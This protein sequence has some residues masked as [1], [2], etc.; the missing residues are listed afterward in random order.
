VGCITWRPWD[1]SFSEDDQVSA[2]GRTAG[3]IFVGVIVGMKLRKILTFLGLLLVVP[4]LLLLN[5]CGGSSSANVITVSVTSSVGTVLILGQSTTLTATVTGSTNTN[6]TW[7]TGVCTYTIIPAGSTKANPA[8]ACPTDGTFGTLTNVQTTGTATYT[9]PTKLPDQTKFPSLALI[10]TATSQANTAKTGTVTIALTSGIA[11][12]LTPVTA[13]VPTKESKPFFVALDNDLQ[14]KGV[15][16]LITQST[17]TSTTTISQLPTCSPGCGTIT[18]L[19]SDPI[20]QA[21][22]TAPATV[23][24]STTVTTTPANVTLVATAVSDN[25]CSTCVAAGTITIIQGGPITFNGISPTIA[26]QGAFYWDIYLDAPNMS[27]STQIALDGV[28]LDPNATSYAQVKI[29]FPIPTSATPTPSSTGARLRLFAPPLAKA[30]P[31]LITLS[32]SGQTVTTPNPASAYTYNVLPVRATSTATVPDDVVQGK[33]A[34]T[35][36]VTVDGG[37]F[38]PGG[39]LA[40]VTFQGS[41]V[42]TDPNT[43]TARRLNASLLTSQI[44]S[45]GP[46]L[47][48]LSVARTIPPVPSPNNPAVTNIAIFPDYSANPPELLTK[49]TP[50][51]PPTPAGINP[52]AMDID[53]AL[54]VVVVAETG[55]NQIQFY[56]VIPPAGLAP[57][58]LTPIDQSGNP[59]ATSCPV[60]ST[61][62]APLN[63]PTGLSVNSSDHTVAVVN[64]GT[65]TKDMN[66]NVV[67]VGQS[68]TVLPIPGAPGTPIAPFSLDI[69]GAYHGAFLG[70]S[71]PIPMPYSIGV[72]PDSKLVLV[73]YSST[74]N[75]SSANLGFVVNLNTGSN[76]PFGCLDPTVTT[77]PC[78]HSQVTLNTGAYPHIAVAAH[79]HL[80][81]VTPGGSGVVQGV[82]LTKKSTSTQIASVSL[83]AGQVTVTTTT[84]H[85]LIP[86]N[87]G[88]VLITGVPNTNN[89][90]V[91]F[92]GVFSVAVTSNMTFTYAL[93]STESDSETGGTNSFVF[94]S[95]PNLLFQISPSLQGIAINP[96]TQTA[97][98]ANAD[99]TG[100]NGA[101]IDMLSAL[102]QSTSSISFSANC[103]AYTVPCNTAPELLATTDV[104][105]QPYTNALISYN[106]QQALVSVSDPNSHQRQ[107]I[108]TGFGPSAVAFP[109]TNGTTGTLTLWGGVVVDSAT[110]HA[111][112]LESGSGPQQAGHI[113][114]VNLG[115]AS[116]NNIKPTQI[117]E[118]I[119][120][121]AT[122]GILGGIPNAL[123][124]Q[125]TLT[126]TTDLSNVKIL[127]SGFGAPAI[128]R[129]DGVSITGSSFPTGSVTVVSSREIDVT[130][131]AAFLSAPHRYSVDLTSTFNGNSVQSNTT[132]FIVVQAIDMSKVCAGG[133]VQPSA[134]AIAD[135]LAN[136]AFSPIA[137]VTNSGCNSI[138]VIDV[139]PTITMGGVTM[140]NPTFGAVRNTV[141]VGTTPQGVAISQRRGL[142]VVANNGD[143]TAS[144]ID[145]TLTTPAAKVPAVAT[146]T[147]PIGVAVD[148][149]LGVAI[150]TNNTS[151]TISELNLGLLF[152]PAGTTP[153]TTLTS[154]SIGGVQQPIAV[155]IDPD[156]GTNNQGIAVVTALQLVS[157]SAPSGAL[158]VVD[159]GLATPSL[160]TTI[161]SG[162]VTA[163]PTGIVFD[164]TVATGTQNPGEFYANSSG[165]N[166]ISVFN[167]DTGGG[168]SV[169]VGINPTSLALNPQTGAIL[170]A[171]SASNTISIVDSLSLPFKTHQTLGIPGSPTF[172]VAIDPFTNLG[173]IVDQANSRVFLFPMPN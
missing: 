99:A 1:E 164:P 152:P 157:G 88:T 47:Y 150:V 78:I 98:L 34:Q 162:S 102:D 146:G 22:Y 107:A 135:Q 33:L 25:N 6:V 166:V 172:G 31:H 170:T 13:T 136:G 138:S 110:N 103:T 48:P 91:D 90:N 16:W 55:S 119:V 134:V 56:K 53:T 72:D 15:T 121:G 49:A 51:V 74:S 161:S 109:V 116:N 108:V 76:P 5:G 94:Y 8:V 11:V 82:D 3:R 37:Y 24:T 29:L 10:F 167:P 80:A 79:S 123:V 23:P 126:S 139:N 159:I 75:L 35:T 81:Y 131:P 46:G 14:S 160:S 66:N 45:V 26:P 158:A 12:H 17:P 58:T 171:N 36:S 101:Q 120:P 39:G 44:N 111:F 132:D 32:D 112:V 87:A 114:I 77:G 50:P 140:P 142:A 67:P 43:S 144:I 2:G 106:P 4:G 129:L 54:G 9:A 147:N 130:I 143:G 65:Q 125:A 86:G 133:N 69:S 153:P 154:T 93:N 156:R 89:K 57:E 73:A 124:P 83:T 62:Q 27:S 30:G 168:S 141:S 163:T 71:N 128:V 38:G 137:V 52:G 113:E 41:T 64:Y 118:L 59:C 61:T 40:P 155:A 151:N 21:T 42:T 84:A 18:P 92:N 95:N 60:S 117:T 115:P 63:V 19:A 127:G 7:N 169:P 122:A 28:A 173:V 104:A 68:V 100:T 20:H 105:W 148:D 97:A 149:G 70:S 85:G 145:L 96:I 165:A